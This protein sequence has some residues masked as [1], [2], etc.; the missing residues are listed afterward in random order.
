MVQFGHY[1]LLGGKTFFLGV[2]E[3]SAFFGQY[4]GN[5]TS[6]NRDPEFQF[7]LAS[8]QVGEWLQFYQ[9]G[10]VADF[11]FGIPFWIFI[12]LASTW[13]AFREWRRKRAAKGKPCRQ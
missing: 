7:R 4:P 13:I 5:R 10:Q 11:G 6:F 2:S 12:V 1:Y 9:S 3:G 8:P